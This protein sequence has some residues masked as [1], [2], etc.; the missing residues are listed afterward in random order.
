MIRFLPMF[1]E[2]GYGIEHRDTHDCL[3]FDL[4]QFL[5][6]QKCRTNL[7]CRFRKVREEIVFLI[8]VNP[9]L[10]LHCCKRHKHRTTSPLCRK[11]NEIA[12]KMDKWTIYHPFILSV[13]TASSRTSL[14]STR[15]FMT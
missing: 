15:S 4:G 1:I 3:I 2:I 10:S 12:D 14:P 8:P 9:Q 13:C 6:T 11:T 7:F 5:H